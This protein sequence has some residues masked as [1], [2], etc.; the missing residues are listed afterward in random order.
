MHKLFSYSIVF[1]AALSSSSLFAEHPQRLFRELRS[2]KAAEAVQGIA[3]D[4]QFVYAVTNRAVGK[5]EKYTGKLV[6]TWE[7]PKELGLQHLNSGVVVD[8]KLYSAHSNWPSEPL[9]NSIQIWDAKT[10]KHIGQR[11]LKASKGAVTWI[12]RRDGHWWIAFAFYGE[13]DNIRRTTLTKFDDDWQQKQSWRF[14]D[15]VIERFA[16]YSNSGGAW[17]PDGLLYATGHDRAEMYALRVPDKGDVLELVDIVPA[18]IEGQGIAW[19]RSDLG[20]AYGIRRKTKEVVA[21]RIS[22]SQEFSQ[23]RQKVVWRRDPANPILPPSK[24]EYD[25]TRCM[26]PWIMRE[27]NE[28]R[29]YYSGGDATGKQRICVATAAVSEPANW[30]RL[31][32]LFDTGAAGAFDARWCV[33]PHVISM[34]AHRWHLYYTG[35]AGRGAGLS[36]FPGVGLAVS[37]NGKSWKRFGGSPV[38]GRSGQHGDPDAIG[39]AGGSVINVKLADGKN[40]WRFYYTGCPTVGSPLPLNQQK[41]ICLATS[42]D[43]IKWKKQG[44]VMLRDPE[45]DYENIGVAGPVVHQN[46][47][48]GFRMWYSAIGTRWGYYSICYAESEDGIHWR[49]G[50]HSG[51]NL[52]LTPQGSGW[53]KQMVEYPSIIREGDRLRMFYC[54]NGY[55][56]TGIG[57]AVSE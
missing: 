28:Y 23:L 52:Q 46:D 57:T 49:R 6:G 47:D 19:D 50:P 9:K 29:L 24:S 54:G 12:D 43:G 42:N 34:S 20:I 36:A 4:E 21:S 17:G 15:K 51:D 38:L 48:G 53:E 3:V 7:S 30:K 40:E 16:P 37:D 32:P 11:E 56:K 25:S 33:L 8:G 55:G 31:G 27:G 26:N 41:T 5:Y 35:N 18:K 39:I 1:V 2:F 45:R 22:H 44:A 10:L 13:I 14:P